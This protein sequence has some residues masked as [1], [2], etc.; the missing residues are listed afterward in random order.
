MHGSRQAPGRLRIIA[1]R[2]RGSKLSVPDAPGL[3]PTPERVRETLFNWL[4]PTIDGAH[5]LDLYAGTGALG[6]EALSR[7]AAHCVFVER[8]AALA[9]ALAD[10]LAR[11]K[12][13]T[14]EVVRGDALSWLA[15]AGE[16]RFD[17]VFVD[18]PFDADAW[19]ATL[20]ALEQ[21]GRLAL[22]AWI[23]VE[24]SAE[25]APAPPAN[26]HLHREGRAG[27]VRHRLYR[28]DPAPAPA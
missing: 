16:R 20:H 7:G 2:L 3:R 12:V 19:Q 8:D 17:L 14:G 15:Q 28:R 10:T 1:G 5:C 4:A 25:Q 22:G 11:L 24:A 9:R 6:L 18:P 13:D 21:G 27:S 26:W 23:H